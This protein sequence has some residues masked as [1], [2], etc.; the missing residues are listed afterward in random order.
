MSEIFFD[1]LWKCAVLAAVFFWT[2]VKAWF[3]HPAA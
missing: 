3:F 1:G 2:I